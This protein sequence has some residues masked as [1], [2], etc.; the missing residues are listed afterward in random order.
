MEPQTESLKP[1]ATKRLSATP[2]SGGRPPPAAPPDGASQILR[3]DFRFQASGSGRVLSSLCTGSMGVQALDLGF[4][5][6]GIGYTGLSLGSMIL[7]RLY[8]DV[9]NAMRSGFLN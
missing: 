5:A 9:S 2:P 4:G 6:S 3:I 1:P 7:Q 8:C